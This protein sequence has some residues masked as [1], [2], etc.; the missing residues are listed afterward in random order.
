MEGVSIDNG[1]K[2]DYI[3]VRFYDKYKI[4]RMTANVYEREGK[5]EE[6]NN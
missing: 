1:I 5:N 3:E 6:S 4:F 2:K